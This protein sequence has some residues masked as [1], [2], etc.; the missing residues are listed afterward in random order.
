MMK[1]QYIPYGGKDIQISTLGDIGDSDV[2]FEESECLSVTKRML[3]LER[4]SSQ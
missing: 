3:C 2:T 1:C 4:L